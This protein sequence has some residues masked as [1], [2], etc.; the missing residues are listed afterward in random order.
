MG[1]DVSKILVVDGIAAVESFESQLQHYKKRLKGQ[2]YLLKKIKAGKKIYEYWY[3]WQYNPQKKNNDWT[4]IG[5]TRP[6]EVKAAPPENELAG[7]FF[8]VVGRDLLFKKNDFAKVEYLFV[9]KHR[10]FSVLP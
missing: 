1:T 8:E 4:Y 9:P 10:V 5:R 2:G 7:V 3:R 6:S